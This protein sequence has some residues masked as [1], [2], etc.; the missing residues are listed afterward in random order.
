MI[1]DKQSPWPQ[2]RDR[3]GT[4]VRDLWR[5]QAQNGTVRPDVWRR[6]DCVRNHQLLRR[7][8]HMDQTSSVPIGV[9]MELICVVTA[10]MKQRNDL[11]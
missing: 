4:I 7:L 3:M 10:Q 5:V 6:D 2:K 11:Q 8:Q 9:R 1:T